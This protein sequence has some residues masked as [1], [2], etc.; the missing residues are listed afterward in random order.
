MAVDGWSL[1][2][3]GRQKAICGHI[4][5]EG[6]RGW[7]REL[8]CAFALKA[9]FLH[10]APGTWGKTEVKE[11]RLWTVSGSNPAMLFRLCDLGQITYPLSARLLL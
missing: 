9:S 10:V 2:M 6:E 8:Q 1:E 5:V 3:P 11:H 4:S 7:L